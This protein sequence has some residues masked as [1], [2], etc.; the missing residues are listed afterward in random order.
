M[1]SGRPSPSAPGTCRSAGRR[2]M[3]CPACHLPEIGQARPRA[4]APFSVS[5]PCDAPVWSSNGWPRTG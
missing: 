1:R 2:Q 4:E 3:T 5:R